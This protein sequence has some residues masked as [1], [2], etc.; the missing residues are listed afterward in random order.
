MI[1]PHILL[2]DEPTNH[3][4]IIAIESLIT[5]LNNFEGAVILITHNLDI[6]TQLDCELWTISNNHQT[7][8]IILRKFM[9][10]KK[11]NNLV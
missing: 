6:I 9:I 10:K 5:A 1:R 11:V 4:D 7:I 8:S 3:L 2:L